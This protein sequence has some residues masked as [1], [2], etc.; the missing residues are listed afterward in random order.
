MDFIR[1]INPPP[2]IPDIL[3]FNFDEVYII[4]NFFRRTLKMENLNF[5]KN[6]FNVKKIHRRRQPINFSTTFI[7]TL[8]NTLISQFNKKFCPSQYTF[9]N[10][11]CKHRLDKV[12]ITH[13][14]EIRLWVIHKKMYL[15]KIVYQMYHI[16][17]KKTHLLEIQVK[18]YQMDNI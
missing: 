14:W 3:S 6:W 2:I 5:W 18:M 9:H 8:I 17:L 4:I 15:I 13:L 10:N 16:K 7:L 1:K 12:Q 11:T